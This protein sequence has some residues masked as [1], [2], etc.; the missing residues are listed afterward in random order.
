MTCIKSDWVGGALLELAWPDYLIACHCLGALG[1]A[2]GI[3]DP[4]WSKAFLEE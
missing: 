1:Q 3:P 2:V 4:V